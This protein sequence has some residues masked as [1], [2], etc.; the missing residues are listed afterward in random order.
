[1][2]ICTYESISRLKLWTVNH[3]I[4]NSDH[5]YT[6]KTVLNLELDEVWMGYRFFNKIIK[7]LKMLISRV[8]KKINI[9]IQTLSLA[10]EALKRQ[11]VLFLKFYIYILYDSAIPLLIFII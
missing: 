6:F 4:G 11:L 10:G 3:K 2:I 7:L 5:K 8:V 1:M 9:W